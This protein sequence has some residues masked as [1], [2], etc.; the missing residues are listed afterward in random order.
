MKP[1]DNPIGVAEETSDTQIKLTYASPPPENNGSAI[2]SYEL[3]MDDGFTGDFF[4]LIGYVTNSKLTT[5]TITTNI[6]KGRQH[7]F[8]Y[9]AK[10][11]VGWGPFSD[12]TAVLAAREPNTPGRV[13]FLSFANDELNLAI[14]IPADNGGSAIEFIE[15][16][17]DEGDDFTS[18]FHQ[19]TNYDGV[20]TTYAAT[21][22]DDS[23]E[24]GKTYRFK[25]RAKN[26]IG[27]SEFSVE[28][29][30]AFGNVPNRPD[31]PTR[32]ASTT[33]SITVQWTAPLANELS[34]SG[35]I[36]NMDDG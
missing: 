28:A 26:L 3:Q 4:T 34:T 16:W 27:Y 14:V 7:R 6:F 23:L 36:L 5:F 24:P 19:L 15:L 25:T 9:R 17:S 20:G 1:S 35:Y 32:I 21:Q 33:T 30:I 8:K 31:A 29:Y 18:E 2:V 12:E 10:N 11:D 13:T 22:A